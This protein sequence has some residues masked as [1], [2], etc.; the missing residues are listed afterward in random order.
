MSQADAVAISRWRY[1]EPYSF[2]D[3][4]ADPGDLAELL[5]P[6]RRGDAWAVEDAAGKLVGHF[7]SRLKEPDA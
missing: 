1:P 3:W 2:Y 4:D 5:D 6:A 7:S